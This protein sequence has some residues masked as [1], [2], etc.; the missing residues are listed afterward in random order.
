MHKILFSIIRKEFFHILRDRQTLIILF[1]MPVMMLLLFGYAITLEM[2]QIETV[3]VDLA[4]NN[5]SRAYIE[6]LTSTN[7]FKIIDSDIPYSEYENIFQSRKAR[8]IVVIPDDFRGQRGNSKIQLLIDASDPNAANYINNYVSQITAKYNLERNPFLVRPLN[9]EPR[10]LY[11]PDL[12][13]AYFFVP[14]LIAVILLLICALLTSIAIVREKESGTFEQILVS[15]V[16]PIQ[17][18]IGK[19][20]PYL[21]IGYLMSLMILFFAHFW[22]NVPIHGSFLL[23]NLMLILYI[24]TGLSFGLLIST[25]TKSQQIALMVTL[26]TTILPT[27]MMSGFIFPI[28]SMPQILQYVAS[29]IPATH[30]LEIIRGIML[31]GIGMHELYPQASYLFIIAVFLVGV[32]V[33]KFSTTLE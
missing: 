9:L 18:I 25:V 10:M 14:G 29:I 4:K 7:F 6:K 8:C 17:I 3:L 28:S 12:K 2:T 32:S 1:L 11:N 5:A 20:V 33:K 23:L 22:F 24:F 31:K 21:G 30:F 27:V 15:P 26:V 19:V 13:S 16:K